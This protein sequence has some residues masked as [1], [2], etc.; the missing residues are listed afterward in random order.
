MNWHEHNWG[1]SLKLVGIPNSF[2]TLTPIFKPNRQKVSTN[3][4]LV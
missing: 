3:S 1:E 4:C 2:A